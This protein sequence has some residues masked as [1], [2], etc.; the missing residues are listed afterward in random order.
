MKPEINA[1]FAGL[2]P[3]IVWAHFE[4]LCSIPRPSGGE[5]TIREHIRDWASGLGLESIVDGTG[6]LIIKKPASPGMEMLPGTIL[7]GHLDMVCQKNEGSAHD[8]SRD[9]IRAIVREGWLLAEETTLGADNGLGVALILAALEDQSLVHGPLE[10]LLTVVE[11]DGMD[12]ARGLAPGLLHGTRLINLD[13]EEWGELYVGCAGGLDVNVSRPGSAVPLPAGAGA[14]SIALTGLRGGHSGI[15]IHEERGNA[16]KLLA[17][18][19]D[20]VCNAFPARLASFH[21]GTARNALPREAFA[22]IALPDGHEDGLAARLAE[23]QSLLRDELAGVDEGLS[24]SLTP[25]VADAVLAEGEQSLWLRA[26]LAAPHGVKRMSRQLPGVVET[27][28]NLGILDLGPQGGSANFMVRSLRGSGAQALGKEISALF[29]LMGA[30]TSV[31]GAYPGWTPDPASPL[32]AR[33]LATY[34]REFES[35]AQVQVIHAGL[36]CGI[37]AGIYPG[38]DMISFGPTIRGAH[39]PGEGVE[40]ATVAGCWRLLKALLSSS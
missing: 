28:N 36:E 39:A 11:E 4:M 22:V 25:A 32:L 31:A 27:S 33:A 26:L 3:G 1:A 35:D 30:D 38:L 13:T 9:P 19:V 12:G 24:L 34:R 8:F 20:D 29:G 18:V 40:I 5:A 15:T 7:Q 16:V 23:W 6:N 10:A 14:F 21:G 37:I 2:E 17:R